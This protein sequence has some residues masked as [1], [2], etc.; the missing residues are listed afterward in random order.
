MPT[1]HFQDKDTGYTLTEF[2]KIS[3]LDEFLRNHPNLLLLPSAPAVT[4]TMGK[5][6]PMKKKDKN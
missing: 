1:Y 6:T 3:E 2:L 5:N 4:G